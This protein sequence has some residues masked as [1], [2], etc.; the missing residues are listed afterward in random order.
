MKPKQIRKALETLYLGGSLWLT[1]RRYVYH[2]VDKTYRMVEVRLSWGRQR[3][4]PG[5]TRSILVVHREPF[6]LTEFQLYGLLLLSEV[7]Q[8]PE[9][10]FSQWCEPHRW[11]EGQEKLEAFRDYLGGLQAAE[12]LGDEDARKEL[13][14]RMQDAGV[15]SPAEL[16]SSIDEIL[17]R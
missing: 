6:M 7:A 12:L 8:R 13:F 10:L 1:P 5:L 17:T 14:L 9:G 16:V 4:L 3:V 15:Y 2:L 11:R